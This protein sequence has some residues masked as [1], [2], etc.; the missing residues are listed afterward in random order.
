M[1]QKLLTTCDLACRLWRGTRETGYYVQYGY[2]SLW[3]FHPCISIH[4]YFIVPNILNNWLYRIG[5]ATT[6][7]DHWYSKQVQIYLNSK[8]E[9]S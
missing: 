5:L 3:K 1:M 8:H 6:I 4:I 7:T 2:Y 9:T